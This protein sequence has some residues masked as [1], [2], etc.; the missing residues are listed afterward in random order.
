MIAFLLFVSGLLS[1]FLL[2]Y[3]GNSFC[4]R[5]VIIAP[6]IVFYPLILLIQYISFDGHSHYL[7]IENSLLAYII[8]LSSMIFIEVLH[9]RNNASHFYDNKYYDVRFISTPRTFFLFFFLVLVFIFRYNNDTYFHISTINEYGGHINFSETSSYFEAT[10]AR[11]KTIGYLP[12]FIFYLKYITSLNVRYI[13]YML[14]FIFFS[15]ILFLPSGKVTFTIGFLPILF[16]LIYTNIRTLKK[17][18]VLFGIIFP[19]LI[20]SVVSIGN[21][22]ENNNDSIFSMT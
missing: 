1:Y 22:R 8:M 10:L 21:Y 4:A 6:F 14:M 11:L 7:L 16:I 3:I 9:R 15:I 17:K 12:I 13:Y 2:R 5:L 18:L 20:L 19:I